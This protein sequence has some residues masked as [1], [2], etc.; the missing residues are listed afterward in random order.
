VVQYLLFLFLLPLNYVDDLLNGTHNQRH[1]AANVIAEMTPMSLPGLL[2][3]EGSSH[4]GL[5]EFAK[6]EVRVRHRLPY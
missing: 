3:M 5:K 2:L 4:A 1:N 6:F